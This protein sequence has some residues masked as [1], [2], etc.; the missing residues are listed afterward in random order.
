MVVLGGC[1]RHRVGVGVGGRDGNF[2]LTVVVFERERVG[3][4]GGVGGQGVEEGGGAGTPGRGGRHRGEVSLLRVDRGRGRDGKGRGLRGG[5]L[6]LATELE[7]HGCGCR[8]GARAWVVRQV[9][10]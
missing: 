4:H 10:M 1:N 2:N 6:V 3:A 8:S 7:G 9:S 5:F